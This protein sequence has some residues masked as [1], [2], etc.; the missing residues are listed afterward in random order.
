MPGSRFL[1]AAIVDDEPQARSR[2]RRLLGGEPDVN[3]V[4]E[5]ADGR[6]AAEAM[7]HLRPDVVFLDIQMPDLDGFGALDELSP[8]E[9]PWIVFVTAYSEHALRAFDVHALDYVL[10]P[11]S[12]DRLHKAIARVRTHMT[13]LAPPEYPSRLG[14]PIGSR[15]RFI[16][17]ETID[18]ILAAANYAEV[19]LGSRSYALRETMSRLERRL[20][21]RLFLRIH[22]S[23][24]V[25]LAC[26][27]DIEPLASGQ[28]VLRLTSGVRLTSGRRYR[29]RLERALGV[30]STGTR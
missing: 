12:P 11:V 18:F 23:R 3:V 21:P 7:R 26:I 16:S 14:V 13:P 5:C 30:A 8:D 25:R 19:Y 1:R 2:L 4:A 27:D 6:A 10:K 29:E 24:I 22:R 20:D 15:T 9:R 17:V 28:Y